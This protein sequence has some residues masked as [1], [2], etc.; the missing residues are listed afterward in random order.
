MRVGGGGRQTLP[1]RG[2]GS[3]TDPRRQPPPTADRRPGKHS[4]PG[5]RGGGH[6]GEERE[7]QV[8]QGPAHGVKSLGGTYGTMMGRGAPTKENQDNYFV[9]T[10]T[11]EQGGSD[12]YVGV[13]D[14][15]GLQGQKLVK[16]L[17]PRH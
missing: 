13:L 14:G 3:Q 1:S 16:H 17:N 5:G 8:Q 15:H 7:R 11:S 9:H 6:G 12:F 10:S 2:G 4:S